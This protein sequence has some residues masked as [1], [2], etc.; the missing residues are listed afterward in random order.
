M[1]H[2]KFERNILSCT[3]FKGN[4]ICKFSVNILPV[5]HITADME[6]SDRYSFMVKL[7]DSQRQCF[8][9]GSK[10]VALHWCPI[11]TAFY[12]QI[13]RC[14]FTR[15]NGNRDGLIRSAITIRFIRKHIL[16]NRYTGQRKGT[17]LF[18]NTDMIGT[19][20][21][22]RMCTDNFT[23]DG[24]RRRQCKIDHRPALFFQRYRTHT[25]FCDTFILRDNLILTVRKAGECIV[26]RSIRTCF[27]DGMIVEIVRD[28]L[29][30]V[31]DHRTLSGICRRRIDNHFTRYRIVTV[32]R[33]LQRI[34]ISRRFRFCRRCGRVTAPAESQCTDQR[35]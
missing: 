6:Q 4:L 7:Q 32:F 8:G 26:P 27:I 16:T 22:D 21:I 35:R 33:F 10:I 23:A 5:S 18:G 3:I 15:I 30:F 11:C 2:F 34:G 25:A 9:Y 31:A 13:D 24:T 1:I 19:R 12:L 29:R 14:H 20:Q 28:N 17:V